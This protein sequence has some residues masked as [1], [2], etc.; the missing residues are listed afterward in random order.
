MSQSSTATITTPPV[1]VVC[2]STFSLTVTVTLAPTMMGLLVASG[3]N[4]V[5]PP[6]R[7]IPRDTGGAGF[8]TV[9]QL[10]PQSKMPPKAYAHYAMDPSQVSFSFRVEPP[11]DLLIYVGV[12]SGVCFLLSGVMLDAYSPIETELLEF[13]PLQPFRAYPWQAYVYPRDGHWPILNTLS[14]CSLH[15]F[16]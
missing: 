1:T 16:E 2:C 8:T 15:C 14:G 12:S 6:P 13:E 10:Q 7:L 9:P 5:V 3:Q 4:D 11:N